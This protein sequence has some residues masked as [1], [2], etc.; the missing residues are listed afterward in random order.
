MALLWALSTPQM[1]VAVGLDQELPHLVS[2]C[3]ESGRVSFQ[4]SDL[5]FHDMQKL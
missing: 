5:E 4:V 2:N 1:I 3:D